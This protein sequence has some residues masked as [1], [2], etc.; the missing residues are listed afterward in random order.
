MICCLERMAHDGNLAVLRQMKLD[1][2]VNFT[3]N[4]LHDTLRPAT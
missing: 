4:F 2:P 3:V 1:F